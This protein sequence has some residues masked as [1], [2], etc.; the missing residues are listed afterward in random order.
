MECN[1]CILFF[2]LTESSV[3]NVA[4]QSS[5]NEITTKQLSCGIGLMQQ[6]PIGIMLPEMICPSDQVSIAYYNHL[7]WGAHLSQ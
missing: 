2:N 1:A 4:E 3:L 7:H 6:W 5:C